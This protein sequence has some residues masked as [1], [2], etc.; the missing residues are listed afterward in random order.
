MTAFR[1][2]NA[3]YVDQKAAK[4]EGGWL[5]SSLAISAVVFAC[6]FGGAL[7]GMLLRAA[8]PQHHLSPESKDGVKLGIGLIATMA[9]LVLGLLIA[10]AKSSFDSQRNEL[11]QMSANVIFLDR[12]LARYGPETR[13]AREGLRG[14]VVSALDRMWPEDRSRPVQVQGTSES[15][16][17]FD[18]LQQLAP[19]NETQRALQAQALKL[20]TD[21]A[22]TRW[23]LFAQ[24]SSSIPLP[25]L[26]IL[27]FWLTIIFASFSLFARLN[28]TLIVALLVFAI[29]ASAALFLILELGQPFTG[30][31]RISDAPLRNALAPLEP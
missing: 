11:T 14:A 20:G 12:V 19:K 21:V 25:F 29:S 6:V 23:L 13:E 26:V 17:V 28:L 30:L 8:L 18:K 15:E 1:T 7:L 5:M 2:K 16:A 24:R 4:R 31:M 22:Q 3:D 9:A 27:V 10:S